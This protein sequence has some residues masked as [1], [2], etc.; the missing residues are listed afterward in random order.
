M[1][2]L[3]RLGDIVL[4]AD[5]HSAEARRFA[6]DLRR[7][8]DAV[9]AAAGA[10]LPREVVTLSFSSTLVASVASAGAAAWCAR[11]D[12]GGEGAVTAERLRTR[13]IDARLVEDAEATA[14]AAR[15]TAVVVGADAVGPGGVVNKVGTR[16]LAEAAR[17]AGAP[18]YVVAGSSKLVAADL[19]APPPFER[20]PLDLITA[21]IGERGPVDPG[22]AARFAASHPVPEALVDLL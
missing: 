22:D 21:V 17:R 10:V 7:E 6:R 19:P 20:T 2:P 18:A 5:D 14:A 9:S 4:S 1:A 11:S 12:P 3:W 15:G 13:G 8:T 16:A